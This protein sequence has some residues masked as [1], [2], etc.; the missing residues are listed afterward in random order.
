M[1]PPVTRSM[2]LP[3]EETLSLFFAG[4]IE[5]ELQRFIDGIDLPPDSSHELSEE[6]VGRVS[7]SAITL[8]SWHELRPQGDTVRTDPEWGRS[9][10]R[11]NASCKAATC[12]I[13]RMNEVVN[14]EFEAQG[15]RR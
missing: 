5:T 15:G 6:E 8:A 10:T 11:P 9:P 7:L 2:P 3:R 4:E 13:Q 14:Y 12:A 1:K